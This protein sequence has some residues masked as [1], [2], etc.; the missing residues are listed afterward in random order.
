MPVETPTGT[1]IR[2]S[3]STTDADADADAAAEALRVAAERCALTDAA[4]IGT[5]PGATRTAPA[6]PIEMTTV[7]AA[8]WSDDELDVLCA[9]LRTLC[10]D[11]ERLDVL[12]QMSLDTRA[13]LRLANT[14]ETDESR[15]E[16][17]L[18]GGAQRP[19]VQECAAAATTTMKTTTTETETET[20]TEDSTRGMSPPCTATPEAAAWRPSTADELALAMGCVQTERG[21]IEIARGLAPALGPLDAAALATLLNTLWTYTYKTLLVKT[22]RSTQPPPL[23]VA[24]VETLLRC[25]DSDQGR[26]ALV[27]SLQWVPDCVESL[28]RILDQM[29]LN[30]CCLKLLGKLWNRMVHAGHLP[31][32]CNRAAR[33]I[34]RCFTSVGHKRRAAAL[35]RSGHDGGGGDVGANPFSADFGWGTPTVADDGTARTPSTEPRRRGYTVTHRLA[36]LRRCYGTERSPA[37]GNDRT[38]PPTPV[39]PTLWRA[40]DTARDVW[41][42]EDRGTT[43]ATTT[44]APR[45]EPGHQPPTSAVPRDRGSAAV[46]IAAPPV[47]RVSPVRPARVSVPDPPPGGEPEED[48]LP[49]DAACVVCLVRRRALAPVDCGHLGMC[50]TCAGE[51]CREGRAT[52]RCPVCRT[53]ISRLLR[54]YA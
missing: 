17:L 52:P 54:V 42:Q 53:A 30:S 24:D 13:L 27:K 45:T 12:R 33:R 21:R 40:T 6:V 37:G 9:W 49:V 51:L 28:A 23:S 5:P 7:T 34:E 18:G 31:E 22:L 36:D 46:W 3:A 15:A 32:D 43:T 25:V 8:V 4:S 38:T 11:R 39:E 41:I 19:A 2:E 16:F 14:L 47:A 44:T 20:E 26:Y 10:G 50:H 29:D 35:V 1:D 48:D